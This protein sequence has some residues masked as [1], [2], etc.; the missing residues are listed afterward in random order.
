MWSV[1]APG[2]ATGDIL[3]HTKSSW[4]SQCTEIACSLLCYS[5]LL[6]GVQRAGAM[7]LSHLCPFVEHIHPCGVYLGRSPCVPFRSGAAL[8]TGTY[9]DHRKRKKL[10]TLC[11]Y[12]I[13]LSC[14]RAK[15]N[16]HGVL[17][18]QEFSFH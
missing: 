11:T 15:Y 3:P 12:C 13:L 16:T 7:T 17:K 1:I 14:R 4:S 9:A 10:K 6:S 2:E 18:I 8:V 5:H